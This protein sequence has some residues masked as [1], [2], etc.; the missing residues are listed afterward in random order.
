M[1]PG[2]IVSMRSCSNP[3]MLEPSELRDVFEGKGYGSIINI[4][5]LGFLKTLQIFTKKREH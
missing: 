2:V 1:L 4:Y 3:A 5:N